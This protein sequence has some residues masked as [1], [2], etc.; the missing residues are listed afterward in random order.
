[1]KS[2]VKIKLNAYP[3]LDKNERLSA[4][5]KARGMWKHRKPDP[6]KELAKIRKEWE[7]GKPTSK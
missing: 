5:E 1:M 7:R 4:W 2:S 6:V 3:M